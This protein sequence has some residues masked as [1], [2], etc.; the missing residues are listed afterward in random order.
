MSLYFIVEPVAPSY[1]ACFDFRKFHRVL[2]IPRLILWFAHIL[3]SA[4]P[5]YAKPEKHSKE[6][7]QIMHE[8]MFVAVEG[9]DHHD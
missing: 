9:A 4:I 6:G 7:L 3:T 2:I 1:L 5:M 8:S